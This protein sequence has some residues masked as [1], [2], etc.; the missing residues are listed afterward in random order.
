MVPDEL[1]KFDI[2]EPAKRTL[3]VAR[4]AAAAPRLCYERSQEAGLPRVWL[5]PGVD[6]FQAA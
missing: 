6:G 2:K 5:T 4:A 3:M 1:P